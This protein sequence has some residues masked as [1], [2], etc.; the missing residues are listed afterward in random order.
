MTAQTYVIRLPSGAEAQI[1]VYS[2]PGREAAESDLAELICCDG[3]DVEWE[4]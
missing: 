1:V 4:R 2:E 3:F